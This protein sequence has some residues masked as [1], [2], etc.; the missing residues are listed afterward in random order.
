MWTSP[1]RPKGSPHRRSDPD[2]LP[3]PAYGHGGAAGRQSRSAGP[4]RPRARGGA[5]TSTGQRGLGPSAET[6]GSVAKDWD[7]CHGEH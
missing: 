5:G 1:K 2:L 3:F 7:G 6:A 4:G